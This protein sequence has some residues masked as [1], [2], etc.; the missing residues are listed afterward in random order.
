MKHFLS[1]TLINWFV[2]ETS[3]AETASP[4][5]RIPPGRGKNAY[6]TLRWTTR[7]I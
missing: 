5:C 7:K 4:N 1:K 6:D 2:A 3:V